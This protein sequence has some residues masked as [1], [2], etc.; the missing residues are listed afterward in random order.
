[1]HEL[2]VIPQLVD[3]D[4][5][6]GY[7]TNQL[8]EKDS[9]KIE[10]SVSLMNEY[11]DHGDADL[12]DESSRG[13]AVIPMC[14]MMSLS[15]WNGYLMNYTCRAIEQ[16][17][18]NS[19]IQGIMMDVNSGG[20][21]VGAAEVY[22]NALRDIKG[23]KPILQYIN[24]VSGSGAVYGGV[25]TD[26]TMMGGQMSQIG[27]IGVMTSLPKWYLQYLKEHVYIYADGSENKNEILQA[28]I[29]NKQKVVKEKELN[30][31]REEFVRVV[32][33]NRP[34]VKDEAL[35][36]S[37]F[38]GDKAVDVGLADA[39]GTKKDA[40]QMIKRMIEVQNLKIR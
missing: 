7:M 17:S 30:P 10:F 27:S 21:E 25:I 33:K 23:T 13:V 9:K 35:T 1:M 4:W 18:M 2:S 20:G 19:S 3:E 16:A 26:K 14:G 40:Y 5:L 22:A 12:T 29:S 34:K 38:R 32:K 36:G 24:Q 39:V 28:L 37:M 15:G 8:K 6:F 31:I 11:G